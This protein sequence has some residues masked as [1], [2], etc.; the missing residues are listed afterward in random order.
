VVNLERVSLL[1]PRLAGSNQPCRYQGK[2]A[3]LF[4]KIVESLIAGRPF[5]YQTKDRTVYYVGQNGVQQISYWLSEIPIVAFVDDDEGNG[6]P[7]DFI[8]CHPVQIIVASPPEGASPNKKW[9]NQ[10][11]YD[12]TFTTLATSLWS[13]EELF[14]TGLA[15]AIL[16][17]TL[18]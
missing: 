3:Y 18:D 14:L 1:S 15:L 13:P 12:T 11:S 10:L 16:L 17:S 2:T 7:E 9:M 6:E 8:C 5:L 4:L